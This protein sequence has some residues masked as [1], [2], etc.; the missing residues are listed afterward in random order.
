M[1][2][3]YCYSIYDCKADGFSNILVFQNEALAL[4]A[5]KSSV[6]NPESVMFN[7]P[8]DFTLFLIGEFEMHSGKLSGCDKVAISTGVQIKASGV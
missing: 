1:D 7:N 6:N 2:K 8:E 3:V 5:F 4:R